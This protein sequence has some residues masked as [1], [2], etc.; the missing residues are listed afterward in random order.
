MSI[1]S[2]IIFE[3]KVDS[4]KSF[5]KRCQQKIEKYEKVKQRKEL[6]IFCPHCQKRFRYICKGKRPRKLR[7]SEGEISFFI[8]QI[9][10][11][12]CNKIY[13]PLVRWLGLKPRQIITEELIDKSLEVAIHTSY[14]TA[15]RLTGSLTGGKIGSRKIRDSMLKKAYCKQGNR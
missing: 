6:K 14:K 4:Q 5:Q 2:Q 15:S 3:S 8:Q 11:K 7:T 1:I 10:C 12:N 13:R 9:Q